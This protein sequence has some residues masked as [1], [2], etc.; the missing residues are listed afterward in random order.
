AWNSHRHLELYFAVSGMGAI[1]HTIN[2]RLFAEQIEYIANHAE[3]SLVFFDLSFTALVQ[4]M[5]PRLPNVRGYV[6][7]ADGGQM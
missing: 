6:A 7:L 1:L 2:P 4:D 3:D 5:A